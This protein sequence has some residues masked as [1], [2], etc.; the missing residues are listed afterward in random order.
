MVQ[1]GE[2]IVL[3]VA[4]ILAVLG[5]VL[6]LFMFFRV[7]P[8]ADNLRPV[9]REVLRE[10]VGG[11]D[12][13][14]QAVREVWDLVQPLY[15]R[16]GVEP[17]A[18]VTL[19]GRPENLKEALRPLFELIDQLAEDAELEYRPTAGQEGTEDGG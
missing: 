5:N 8:T 4:L 10:N 18:S 19:T 2:R 3:T 12:E 13:Y 6:A 7:A 16:L 9:V 14:T 15:L 1:P 11:E 17:P